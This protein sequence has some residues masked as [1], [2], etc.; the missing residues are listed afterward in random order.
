MI[1]TGLYL[2][3][4]SINDILVSYIFFNVICVAAIWISYLKDKTEEIIINQARKD[5]KLKEIGFV[6]SSIIHEIINPLA[7]IRQSLEVLK[8]R[9]NETESGT[10]E[11]TFLNKY[12]DMAQRNAI[13]IH[14][15]ITSINSLVKY[16][17]NYHLPIYSTHSLLRELN[18]LIPQFEND[19]GITIKIQANLQ[20]FYLEGKES[21]VVQILTNLIRNS[22]K[23]I[24]RPEYAKVWLEIEE[25]DG[26]LTFKVCDNGPGLSKKIETKMGEPPLSLHRFD[27]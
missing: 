19:Y 26:N 5:A 16:D 8:V 23:A 3:D 9:G 25:G 2:T 7:A 27:I 21:E 4:V 10:L 13:N 18:N 22:C 14:E 1:N 17:H 12:V 15:I 6:S 11:K 20:D 24:D